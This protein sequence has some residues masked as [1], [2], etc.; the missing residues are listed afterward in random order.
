S[1]HARLPIPEGMGQREAIG[2]LHLAADNFVAAAAEYQAA[3][4]EL[5]HDAPG[6]R[7]RLL[8]RLAD[9]LDQGGEWDAAIQALGEARTLA[10]ELADPRLNAHVASGLAHALISVGEYRRS[11]RYGHYAYAILRN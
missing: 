6:E 3:L 2:D 9:T 7:C 1:S 5:G 10:R 11:R 4:R 8:L